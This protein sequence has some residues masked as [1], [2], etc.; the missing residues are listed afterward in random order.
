[1][2]GVLGVFGGVFEGRLP[3]NFIMVGG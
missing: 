3:D 1:V 2:L